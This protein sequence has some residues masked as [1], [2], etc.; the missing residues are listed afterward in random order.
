[1]FG[2]KTLT[3]YEGMGRLLENSF[4]N[5]KNTSFEIVADVDT[6]GA[7]TNGVLVQ[8]A[9]KFGGWS[10]Y[11]QA[12]KPIFAY[13]YLGLETYK[14]TSDVALPEGEA[15]VKVDFA[16]DGGKPGA[17]GTATLFIDGKEVGSGRI[18]RTQAAVFSADETANV[19][20]D[21]ETPVVPDYATEDVR[22]TGK[23]EKI[24]I[25]LK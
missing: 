14:A 22:F 10:F 4:I 18:E 19:G 1:M 17:G 6:Q 13:N 25:N 16:W 9:G 2:R 12:G 7:D 21:L 5:V 20:E 11:V 23:I 15:T 24:T 3:L 8:Q